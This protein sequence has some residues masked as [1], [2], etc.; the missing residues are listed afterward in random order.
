[1][2]ERTHGCSVKRQR[3]AV[4]ESAL[5]NLDVISQIASFLEAKD[6]CQVQATCKALGSTNDG[7]AFNGLSITEEAAR[8]VFESATEEERV[9]LPRYNRESWIE[10]YHHLLMLRARLT[11]DQLVGRFVEYRGGDK[12]AV[13]GEKIDNIR[14]FG[15]AIC[16]NHIMRAGKHWATITGSS[17]FKNGQNVGVV[18]PLPGWE[19]NGLRWFNPA[20]PQFH[21][22]LQRE[23][24]DRWEGDVHYCYFI[25]DYGGCHWSDWRGEFATSTNWGRSD[26]Y[27]R[28]CTILGVLLDLDSGT[29]SVYQNGRRLGTLKDG[30]AGEY[31]WIAGF[32]SAGDLSIQR[33]YE[34]TA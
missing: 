16:I 24:T 12:A 11:F 6:L 2:A 5:A 27:S 23:R 25:L 20:I 7:A 13:E 32:W 10:L 21:L 14:E 3:V 8:R 30:L 18:R 4:V 29:L 22:A 26:N 9:M 34:A 15:S 19:K 17:S 31:C 28:E 1:M 33:G